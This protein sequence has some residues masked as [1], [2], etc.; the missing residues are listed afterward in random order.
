MKLSDSE[1]R[2]SPF[3]L[4]DPPAASRPRTRRRPTRRPAA[5]S[6]AAESALVRRSYC[7]FEGRTSVFGDASTAPS[8]ESLATFRAIIKHA[9][10][11]T[12]FD[13]GFTPRVLREAALELRRHEQTQWTRRD[14]GP[15]PALRLKLAISGWF[16]ATERR[17]SSHTRAS[18]GAGE[19]AG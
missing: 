5:M 19:V 8:R 17:L 10:K 16:R 18:P 2:C 15:R 3:L 4:L 7:L 9:G 1:T 11:V 12:A 14:L 6:D 13:R